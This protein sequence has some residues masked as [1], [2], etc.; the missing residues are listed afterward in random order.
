VFSS[1]ILYRAQFD[2]H[3][4]QPDELGLKKGD[5]YN[6]SEKCHDGW[7]KG[8]DLKTGKIGVFPGNYVQQYDYKQAKKLKHHKPAAAKPDGDLI[9]L[10]DGKP[11]NEKVEPTE[12]D[13]ERIEKLKKIRETLRTSH[14]QAVARSQAGGAGNTK[15]RG[16]RYRCVVA[17]P[18]S[19]DYELELKVG[20]TLSLV[21]KREDGWCKGTLHR[22]GKTGL[23][24]A[25][26]VEKVL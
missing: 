20:D 10:S 19:S 25:S 15:P 5:L 7:F 17:F 2:F 3:P 6:V 1:P 26:F 18:A 13:A 8:L 11:K 14:E 23:F 22:T 21:K 4:S 16:D 12:T 24:P 9:D